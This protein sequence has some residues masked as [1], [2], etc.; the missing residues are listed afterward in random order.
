MNALTPVAAESARSPKAVDHLIGARIRARRG[1]LGMSQTELAEAAGVT[2]QQ[3]QKYERGANRVSVGRLLEIARK[4]ERPIGYF[5]K[6]VER[7]DDA[8]LGE[9]ELQLIRHDRGPAFIEA[10]TALFETGSDEQISCTL[11]IVRQ[12]KAAAQ[13]C[14][15]KAA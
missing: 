12:I 15:G 6:D 5:I 3:I 8:K 13:A 1:E 11:N 4:L 7:T 10:I 2:F 14:S 9:T